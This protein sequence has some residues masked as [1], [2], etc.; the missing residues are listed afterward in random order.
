M[1]EV[2]TPGNDTVQTRWLRRPQL[3]AGAEVC[4]FVT[5]AAGGTMQEHSIY[6]A[7]SWADAG[8]SVVLLLITDTFDR[9]VK[10]DGLAFASGLLVRENRGY[11]FGAWASG[12]EQLPEVRTAS[13]VA[14]VNDSVYGP[15]DTFGRMLER[16]RQMDADVIGATESAQYARHFQSFLLF[17]KPRALNNDAFW[18]F[19]RNVRAGGRTVAIYRYELG[20]VRALERAGLSCEAL[21][22]TPDSRNPTY[23]RWRELIEDG[24]PYL[25][26]SL[27]RKRRLRSH[28]SGWKQLLHDRGYDPM[29]VERH[30]QNRSPGTNNAI[31]ADT[32]GPRKN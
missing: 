5:Y 23:R 13:L 1:I 19:W 31:S 16:V 11:D 4:L 18:R 26:T 10:T 2:V 8:F 12:L 6:H 15:F 29:I 32:G 28:L 20:L 27:L 22:A 14:L 25:K 7:R 3:P 17:F 24:F 21:F 9:D 30:I